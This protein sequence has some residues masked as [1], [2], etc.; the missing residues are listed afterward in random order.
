MFAPPPKRYFVFKDITKKPELSEYVA[1]IVERVEQY[2]G[3]ELLV[4]DGESIL[5]GVSGGVDSI[6]LLDILHIL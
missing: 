1:R 5:I 4:E 6:V 2:L 3:Q